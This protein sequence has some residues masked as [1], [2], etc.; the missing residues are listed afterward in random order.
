MKEYISEHTEYTKEEALAKAIA[1][2]DSRIGE[3][4][5]GEVLS[6][7][8]EWF[9]DD[10]ADCVTLKGEVALLTD[11]ASEAPVQISASP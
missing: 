4:K 10:A 9:Y 6:K 11:I 8:Y 1:A 5:D 3:I 2:F 7:S